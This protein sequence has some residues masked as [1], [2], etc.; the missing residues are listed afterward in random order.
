[1]KKL[2]VF[3]TISLVSLPGISQ[4]LAAPPVSTSPVSITVYDRTRVDAV[5][6]FTA[7]P[8][9][10]TYG[11]LES[12]LR[13]GIAQKRRQFDWQ[14]E[15]IQPSVLFLPSDAVSTVAAQ[16]QLGLGGTYFAANNNQTENAAGALKLGFIRFHGSNPGHSLRIGRFE[17][18]DGQETT[19]KNTDLL[20]LQTNH[21][22]ARMIG[23]FGFSDGQRSFDGIDG[24]YNG[25]TW[26]ITAMGARADQ[27][28]YNMNANP[29]L[30]VDLQYLAY[31][32][33]DFKDHLLWRV[34]AMDYHDGRTGLTKTDNRP[35]AVRL[36]D[37]RN[38]RLGSYGA[39]FLTTVPVGAGKVDMLAW[40]VLQNGNW[41][42]LNQHAGATAVEGGY[43]ATQVPTA[44]W[45]RGG[46]VRSTGDNNA[47]DAR[48]NTFFQVLPTPRTYARFPFYNMMNSKDQF[49]QL[50]DKPAKKLDVRTD[51]HFLQLTSNNDLWYQG[52]GAY[53]NKV[54]GYVGRPAN[55]HS[56]FSSVF[57]A[58][59]DYQVSPSIALTA[60]YAR[61]WGK[62]V[63]AAI[64]PVG[65]TA[66]F[67]Y[68][69]MTYRWGKQQRP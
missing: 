37:H 7:T 47:S 11:Y 44:P 42:L 67:G 26:D 53:D 54:F 17:F 5:Q 21:M 19:P 22:A 13:V 30:N 46:F 65:H 59:V 49:V 69:E 61:A 52:G 9:A 3:C 15:L 31:S 4:K 25:K 1:L 27:G 43:H 68:M 41:G 12:L 40:G 50:M 24:H 36:T 57:D 60:Y 35:L 33:Y 48:N 29:E 16:G 62:S 8:T 2:C 28:V 66:Q 45:L 51:M 23:N 18:F 10:E 39:D 56:S 55:L 20:Y 58:S 63:V 64:Y 34:F 38:I 14:L 32:K 6:W